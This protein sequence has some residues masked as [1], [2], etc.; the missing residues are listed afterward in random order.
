MFSRADLGELEGAGIVLSEA[1]SFLSASESA[2]EQEGADASE[3]LKLTLRD[4][5]AGSTLYH[6]IASLC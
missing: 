3:I 2:K 5:H 4:S 1:T 6:T